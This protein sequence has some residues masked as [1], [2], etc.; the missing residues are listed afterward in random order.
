M[1]VPVAVVAVVTVV[2]VVVAPLALTLAGLI[3][4]VARAHA[5]GLR[6]PLRHANEFL[7]RTPPQMDDTTQHARDTHVFFFPAMSSILR[8]SAR[9]AAASWGPRTFASRAGAAAARRGGVVDA[10]DDK[11]L[12]P[13]PVAAAPDA[14]HDTRLNPGTPLDIGWVQSVRVNKSAVESRASEIGTRRS[15]KK[16]WQAA[17]L[18]RALSCVDLTTLAGE[19]V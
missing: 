19:R 17:W 13:P 14:A 6:S 12:T 8:S 9:A 5:R 10:S 1:A 4:R 11:P 7:K 15:V 16:E 3:C 18:L 2:P